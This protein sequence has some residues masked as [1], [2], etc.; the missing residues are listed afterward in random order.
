MERSCKI[1][2]E[3]QDVSKVKDYVQK[4]C[5]KLVNGKINLK[6]FIIAKEYRGRD[7]YDNAKSIAACQ[8]ANKALLK[9][10]LA[11]PL[12]SEYLFWLLDLIITYIQTNS[13]LF[14]KKK[15]K[16]SSLFNCLRDS[17]STTL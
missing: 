16:K 5:N 8:I 11:E 6:D 14:K 2:F 12:I 9:D 17:K 13:F 7:S 15:L 1:L 3:F 4:Q 10:P